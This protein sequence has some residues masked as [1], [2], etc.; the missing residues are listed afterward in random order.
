[1]LGLLEGQVL[2]NALFQPRNG[3]ALERITVEIAVDAAP[4]EEN[5]Q[6]LV[7]GR[8]RVGRPLP[9]NAAAHEEGAQGQGRAVF[10]LGDASVL[11]Q[12]TDGCA[13]ATDR[14]RCVVQEVNRVITKLLAK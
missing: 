11:A 10:K 8:E 1:M 4:P 5:R 12:E 3:Y 14:R 2:R 7:V 6:R 9:L 13:V